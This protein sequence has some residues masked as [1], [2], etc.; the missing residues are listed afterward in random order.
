MFANIRY[1]RRKGGEY[2]RGYRRKDGKLHS[3]NSLT[4][5]LRVALGKLSK[6]SH[7]PDRKT[8]GGKLTTIFLSEEFVFQNMPE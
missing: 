7:I 2:H 1:S 5:G 4:E 8:S 6:Q 3:I